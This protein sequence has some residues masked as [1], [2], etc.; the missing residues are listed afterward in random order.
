MTR[1]TFFLLLFLITILFFSSTFF[2][3][4]TQDDFFHLQISQ[5]KNF[6]DFISFF[7]FNNDYGYMFYRPLTTQVFL[8][9]GRALFGL[10]PF[11][12]HLISFLFFVTNIYLVFK[13][14]KVLLGE[15]P[16]FISSA[17]YALSASHFSTLAYISTF[18]EVGVAFF[19]FLTVF[20]YLKKSPFSYL[21]FILALA[22]RE[23]AITLPIIIFLL[24]FWRE[25]KFLRTFPYFLTLFFYF[26][27]RVKYFNI[28][29]EL[30]YQPVFSITKIFNTV[31]WY[32][33][34]SF[35]LPESL[36]DFVGPGLKVN[37]RFWQ[38]SGWRG[39]AIVSGSL[40]MFFFCG[41]MLLKSFFKKEKLKKVFLFL[42]WF[43]ITLL[44]FLFL[45]QHKFVYYLEVPLLGFCG[46]IALLLAERR[47]KTIVFFL[48]IFILVSFLT[49]GF[50]KET[51][52]VVGR[53]KLA[54]NSISHL[55]TTYPQLPK[56]ATI[57]FKNGS[58]FPEAPSAW[59]GASQQAKV[60]LSDCNGPRLIYHDD[61]LKCL[62]EDDGQDFRE[63]YFLFV[64]NKE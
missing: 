44:P 23:T 58:D 16:A 9:F 19:Y 28:P 2:Y 8:F 53:A 43:L 32:V 30:V 10:N 15:K 56:G 37:P 50:Y 7:S 59:G 64:V 22:S 14:T 18:E 47:T 25:K 60:A 40:F 38:I 6:H 24:E 34:W 1:K 63:D 55:K 42:S 27:L 3:Y 57:Y 31:L 29:A 4:F 62:Y 35:G 21:S 54:K 17:L 41:L 48:G 33:F 12:F 5:A 61:S 11:G 49:I 36:V 52:W 39:K 26:F 20:L 45:P 46:L 51:Y 13:I